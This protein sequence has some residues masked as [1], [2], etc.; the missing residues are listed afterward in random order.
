MSYGFASLIPR[1]LLGTL[2]AFSLLTATLP[3]RA[4]IV[5][6][7][8]AYQNGSTKYSNGRKIAYD[9]R[10]RL[11]AVFTQNIAGKAG[12]PGF[13]AYSDDQGTTWTTGLDDLDQGTAENSEWGNFT[14]AVA[15]GSDDSVH[16]VWYAAYKAAQYKSIFYAVS[17]D[18]GTTWTRPEVVT[19]KMS[20]GVYT[21]P[22]L[23]LDKE[24]RPHVVFSDPQGSKAGF[25]STKD[26]SGAWKM[27]VK[28]S[29]SSTPKDTVGIEFNPYLGPNGALFVFFDSSGNL[30]TVRVNRSDDGGAS[31]TG[32]STPA[33][34]GSRVLWP[35]MTFDRAGNSYLTMTLNSGSAFKIWILKRDPSGNWSKP[36]I[37]NLFPPE[38]VKGYMRSSLTIDGDDNLHVFVEGSPESRANWDIWHTSASLSDLN[39]WEQPRRISDQTKGDNAFV[40]TPSN[41]RGLNYIPVLWSSGDLADAETGHS[42][43]NLPNN[44][45]TSVLFNP[46]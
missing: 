8:G 37:D 10:G 16:V 5:V 11:H 31:W 9:S 14:P 13:Y 4:G 24:N 2:S 7:E 43:G 38:K 23:T 45:K 30:G 1:M 36:D 42:S 26:A 15:V 19:A 27:P 34:T 22:S 12:N 46:F 39:A 3:A 21:W 44:G 40:S 28:I 41:V 20:P 18:R 33:T 17:R 29:D 32:L 35:S 25:Y 6:S